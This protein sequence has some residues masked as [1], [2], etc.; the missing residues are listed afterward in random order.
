MVS[1][2]KMG[3]T[4]IR[5]S[6]IAIAETAIAANAGN[7]SHVSFPTR[8]WVKTKKPVRKISKYRAHMRIEG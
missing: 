3:S 5:N 1:Y 7:H 8:F 6:G 2:V 4:V